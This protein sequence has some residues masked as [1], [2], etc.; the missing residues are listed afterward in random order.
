MNNN[1]SESEYG[2]FGNYGSWGE[3]LQHSK[4]YDDPIIL[5]KVKNAILKVKSGEAVYERD[6]V[7]FDKVQYSYPLLAYLLFIATSKEQKL[8]ILDFG[9]S[10]GSS[11]FQCRNFMNHF[12]Q[13][14]WNI[15]E[16][17]H[18]FECGRRLFQDG[19]LSFYDGI[20][21]CCNKE[22]PDVILLSGVL[23]CLEN[24]Y[25]ILTEAMG[26]GFEYIIVA[27]TLFIDQ[28][29]RITIQKVPP[30]IYESSYP[31][32]FFNYDRFH[33][34]FKGQYELIDETDTEEGFRFEDGTLSQSK[35]ILFRRY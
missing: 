15:V 12:R 29:D 7:L 24:P 23:Q 27:R 14:K 17:K 26:Y 25:E 5:D 28:P 18:F 19:V 33:S 22:S 3:A 8:S 20:E 16:Q 6:S 32:W 13:L 35:A 11:Y 10:L 9:G 30:D 34:F 4:G 2:F 1:M 31:I 21:E